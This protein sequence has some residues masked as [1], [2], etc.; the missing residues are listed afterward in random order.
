MK[1]RCC[2]LFLLA[3]TTLVV[4]SVAPIQAERPP[5]TFDLQVT[6]DYPGATRTYAYGINDSGV[7]AG[8]YNDASGMHGFTY[9]G[10]RFSRPLNDPNEHSHTTAATGINNENTVSGYYVGADLTYHNFFATGTIFT[11]LETGVA[12]SLVLGV[13][14]AGNV[15][16]S[17]QGLTLGFVVIDGTTTT[18]TIPGADSTTVNGIN[19]LNECVG[20][21]TSHGVTSG[22]LREPDGHLIYPIAAAGKISTVLNGIDDRGEMVGAVVDSTGIH[23][24][25]FTSP[26]H[27]VTWD[28]PGGDNPPTTYFIGINRRGQISG[29]NVGTASG[30]GFIV[31]KSGGR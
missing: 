20:S 15:C 27:Y 30:H 14:D 18:F 29:F 19:N 31:L 21:Y 10:K 24:A 9:D 23:A 2:S 1:P 4:L 16:G 25:L 12:N 28:Y 26:T 13:N 22:F 11:E 17:A 3:A 8:F 6:L 7:L 5:I